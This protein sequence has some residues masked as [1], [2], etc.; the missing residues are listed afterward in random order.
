M[1]LLTGTRMKTID[2]TGKRFGHIIVVSSAKTIRVGKEGQTKPT[3]NCRCDCGV[4]LRVQGQSLRTGNTKSC[5]CLGNHER[6]YHISREEKIWRAMIYRCHNP[7]AS[8][9]HKYGKKGIKV[10]VK[11]RNSFQLFLDYV[12]PSPSKRHSI[13]RY[14]NSK[15]DYKPGNVRWATPPQQARSKM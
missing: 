1:S 11:W 8:N 14:P 3:W 13:D 2:L 7:S 10:C 15:G 4:T 9:Y 12:G 6:K 5:G